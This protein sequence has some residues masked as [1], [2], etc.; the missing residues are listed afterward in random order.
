M[1]AG[2][3]S[4]LVLESLPFV[5]LIIFLEFFQY[6]HHPATTKLYYPCFLELF[7]EVQH[8][9]WTIVKITLHVTHKVY[10]TTG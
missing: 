4:S 10:Q 7:N 3:F 1:Q 8:I 9:E 2:C 6:L 5:G